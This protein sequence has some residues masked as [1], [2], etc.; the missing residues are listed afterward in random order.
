MKELVVQ[1]KENEYD[2]LVKL[3]Q[4]LDFVTIIENNK[5]QKEL[6]KTNLRSQL[7]QGLTEAKLWEEGKLELRSAKDFLKEL[8]AEI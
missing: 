7:T 5:A 3:L 1:V 4:K 8:E 6:E 2:F